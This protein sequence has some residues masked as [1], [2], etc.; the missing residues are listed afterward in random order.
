MS[1]Y[2]DIYVDRPAQFTDVLNGVI[3]YFLSCSHLTMLRMVLLALFVQRELD[4]EK[5]A[6][7]ELAERCE[8]LQ[9][10]VR[11]QAGLSVLFYTNLCIYLPY[12]H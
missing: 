11:S 6:K 8:Q 3:M 9:L 2:V 1:P 7:H 12:Y 10:Q 5:K 4:N